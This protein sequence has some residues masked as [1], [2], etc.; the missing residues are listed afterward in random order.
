VVFFQSSNPFPP[1][2]FVKETLKE[3]AEKAVLSLLL[4]LLSLAEPRL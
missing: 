4:F 2:S 3:Y 1:V